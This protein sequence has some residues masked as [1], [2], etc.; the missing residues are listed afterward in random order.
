[1]FADDWSLKMLA[2][3]RAHTLLQANPVRTKKYKTLSAT[4]KYTVGLVG[5]IIFVYFAFR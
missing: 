5:F 1:M 2:P 3:G 4:L